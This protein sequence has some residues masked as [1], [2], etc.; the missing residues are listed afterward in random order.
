[1]RAFAVVGALFVASG[2]LLLV[3]PRALGTAFCRAGKAT[4][5]S[6][7]NLI[8]RAV[9]GQIYDESTAPRKMRVMGWVVLVEGLVLLAIGLYYK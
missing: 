1:M 4:S 5:R 8:F 2:I 7:R 9:A 3:F 6:G